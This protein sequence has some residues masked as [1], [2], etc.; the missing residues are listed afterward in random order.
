MNIC[1]TRCRI[2]IGF[3]LLFLG[4]V[5]E[6]NICMAQYKMVIE[7]NDGSYVK[8]L[9]SDIKEVRFEE[10]TDEVIT[11]EYNGNSANDIFTIAN[12][13]IRATEL[14]SDFGSVVNFS[15]GFYASDFHEYIPGTG[16]KVRIGASGF[17]SF[18]LVF[19][20]SEFNPIAGHVYANSMVNTTQTWT[21]DTAS[22]FRMSRPNGMYVSWSQ[23]EKMPLQ[24]N[25]WENKT[26]LFCGTSIPG[27]GYPNIV[28]DMLQ[29]NIV[30]KSV[31]AS[32]VSAYKRNG[33]IIGGENGQKSFS[34]TKQEK[35]ILYGA[36]YEKYSYESIL[37]PY[38]DGTY[39][40]PDLFVLEYG[41]DYNQEQIKADMAKL[42]ENATSTIGV[43]T[44]TQSL[45][46]NYN[47]CTYTGA[48]L[49]IINKIREYNPNAKIAI[50]GF[51]NKMRRPEQVDAQQLV[52]N[53]CQLPMC[54]VAAYIEWNDS[55][56]PGSQSLYNRKH[57]PYYSS[58]M[59]VT[60]FKIWCP[61]D[62]HPHTSHVINRY[63]YKDSNYIIAD[64]IMNFIKDIE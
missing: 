37:I 18:G 43:D 6:G 48:M 11:V 23:E 56:T 26:I 13:G 58:D 3:I 14:S 41:S 21:N 9:T 20:D 64:I 59:D 53:Y 60:N 55:I 44:L 51:M 15:G 62:W 57:A 47:R 5:G 35:R 17:S 45:G 30:N 63:G 24:N 40:M 27:G 7:K 10:V 61:D 19:Y 34:Q 50:V 29:V 2:A 36:D 33:D 32:I 25:T 39:P 54:D 52:A 49:F 42:N 28:G 12:A 31:G 22:Y 46:V 1:F 4:S 8:Y 16:I 38:L